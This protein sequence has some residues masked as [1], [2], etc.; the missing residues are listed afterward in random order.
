MAY[1]RRPVVASAAAT[2]LQRH[3]EVVEAARAGVDAAGRALPDALLEDPARLVDLFKAAAVEAIRTDAPPGVAE[4]L[5]LGVRT[6]TERVGRLRANVFVA[7]QLSSLQGLRDPGEITSAL[8]NRIAEAPDEA[9]RAALERMVAVAD[10]A[11]VFLGPDG[12]PS[13]ATEPGEIGGGPIN[14]P[15]PE[16]GTPEPGTGTTEPEPGTGTTE[17][18]TTEPGGGTPEPGTGTID[19]GTTEPGRTGLESPDPFVVLAEAG[20]QIGAEIG[21]QLGVPDGFQRGAEIGAIWGPQFTTTAVAET[22]GSSASSRFF[23]YV[24]AAVGFALAGPAGAAA[25][26]TFGAAFG[27]SGVGVTISHAVGTVLNLI[28]EEVGEETIHDVT[29]V[30]ACVLCGPLC[31]VCVLAADAGGT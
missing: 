22:A 31:I 28:I 29:T 2:W 21:R 18:G 17:P 5:L 7:G 14:L 30:V 19:T 23:S 13:I 6:M 27:T 4:E 15:L 25:G 12:E 16:P 26:A 10:S 11:A 3:R 1:Q 9:S 24:G 20:S 8:R